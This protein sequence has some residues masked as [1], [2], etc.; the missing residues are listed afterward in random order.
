[1]IKIDYYKLTFPSS[2][3]KN[4]HN[5]F[6]LSLLKTRTR[7]ILALKCWGLSVVAIYQYFF[8]YFLLFYKAWKNVFWVLPNCQWWSLWTSESEFL[9][10]N[11][12]CFSHFLK[13]NLSLQS[14]IL[15]SLSIFMLLYISD[16]LFSPFRF[17]QV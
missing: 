7:L 5:N 12:F 9:S 3:T 16:F 4:I 1:M 17:F 14:T 8:Y 15:Q 10:D 2:G 11:H 13:A 6:V